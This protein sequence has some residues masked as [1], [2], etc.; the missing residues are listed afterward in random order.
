M[1][2]EISDESQR[3]QMRVELVD[4]GERRAEDVLGDVADGDVV[5]KANA[6]GHVLETAFAGDR[7]HFLSQSATE[8]ESGA[9]GA[10]PKCQLFP[11]V[12]DAIENLQ[13]L[14]DR[15]LAEVPILG[16]VELPQ[17]FHQSR[18]VDV[19]VVIEVAK[20]PEKRRRRNAV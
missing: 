3:L 19:V 12:V 20:P 1:L 8:A 4:D 7:R 9:S 6:I 10:E 5:R 11:I 14:G 16:V 15:R 18:N 2:I 13:R 17:F